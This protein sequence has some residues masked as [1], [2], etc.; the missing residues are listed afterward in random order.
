MSRC[1]SNRRTPSHRDASVGI[2]SPPLGVLVSRIWSYSS[3]ETQCFPCSFLRMIEEN[4]SSCRTTFHAVPYCH[5]QHRP[6]QL[7]CS[8]MSFLVPCWRTRNGK[9]S[10]RIHRNGPLRDAKNKQLP[11]SVLQQNQ[12]QGGMIVL[13]CTP[14]KRNWLISS[15]LGSYKAPMQRELLQYWTF[16]SVAFGNVKIPWS[17]KWYQVKIS[18]LSPADQIDWWPFFLVLPTRVIWGFPKRT[19]SDKGRV[20]NAG[21]L[22]AHLMLM[23]RRRAAD[24]HTDSVATS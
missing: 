2:W 14:R 13:N 17:L 20:E 11:P 4:M 22:F 18:S 19:W 7:A 3:A 9:K 1:I 6:S 5:S 23:K 8:E 21:T 10:G 24:S 15:I 16:S 12:L